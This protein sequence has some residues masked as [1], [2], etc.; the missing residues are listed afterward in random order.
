MASNRIAELRQE[1]QWSR[2][3][4]AAKVGV[5]EKVMYRWETGATPVPADSIPVMADI[6][7]VSVVTVMGWGNSEPGEAA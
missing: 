4:L 6:F 2:T 3:E 5:S 7:G 1:R